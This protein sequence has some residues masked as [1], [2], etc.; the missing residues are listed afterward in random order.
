MEEQNKVELEIFTDE[1]TG[2]TVVTLNSLKAFL[3]VKQKEIAKEPN[4][5]IRVGRLALISFLR[6]SILEQND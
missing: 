5:K 4:D 2:K 1:H 6:R 3:D